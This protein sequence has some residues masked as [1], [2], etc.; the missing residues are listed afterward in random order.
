MG[1][2]RLLKVPYH[3]PFQRETHPSQELLLLL[4]GDVAETGL[5]KDYAS[6]RWLRNTRIRKKG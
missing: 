2:A 1:C 3:L 4:E 6:A 5:S